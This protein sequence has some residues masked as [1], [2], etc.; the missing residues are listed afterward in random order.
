VRK[1]AKGGFFSPG[2]LPCPAKENGI[3]KIATVE[4][5]S[6]LGIFGLWTDYTTIVTGE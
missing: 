6:T 3:S 1:P 2:R 4:H 5:Y